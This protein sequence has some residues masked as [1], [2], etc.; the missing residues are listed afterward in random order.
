MSQKKSKK[1]NDFEYQ[2]SF[3]SVLDELSEEDANRIMRG[4]LTLLIEKLNSKSKPEN[5]GKENQAS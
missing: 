1:E 3:E 5:D 2:I 4:V